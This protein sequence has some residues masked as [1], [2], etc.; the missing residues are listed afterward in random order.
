MISFGVTVHALVA[1]PAPH[2]AEDGH[3]KLRLMYVSETPV[4]LECATGVPDC[5]VTHLL[6][7]E[8][9]P[10]RLFVPPLLDMLLA[11]RHYGP[12]VLHTFSFVSR[13]V[14][15]EDCTPALRHFSDFAQLLLNPD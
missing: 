1:L 15:T 7:T 10:K 14:E 6:V 11:R 13:P 12:G 5:K 4:R 2:E 3:L 8:L 9:D